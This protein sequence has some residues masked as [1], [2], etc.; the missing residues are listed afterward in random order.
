MCVC[1]CVC[2]CV[3]LVDF[4]SNM[5][6]AAIFGVDN[7]PVV[8]L[9]LTNS[10]VLTD[11]DQYLNHQCPL[12]TLKKYP[13]SNINNKLDFNCFSYSFVILALIVFVVI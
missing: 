13:N 4:H 10:C 7:L 6:E 5:A 3:W 8:L 1:V 2:V 9:P 12:N 11:N